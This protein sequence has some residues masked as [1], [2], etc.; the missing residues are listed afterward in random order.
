ME[1]DFNQ[2]QSRYLPH[3]VHWVHSVWLITPQFLEI[4]SPDEQKL[5]VEQDLLFEV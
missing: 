4:Y 1:T 2:F 3:L 5:Q